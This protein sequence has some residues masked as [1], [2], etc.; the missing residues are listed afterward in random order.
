MGKAKNKIS[1]WSVYSKAL[2]NRGSI[3]FWIDDKAIDGCHCETHHGGR[4][5]G[6][7]FYDTAIE[8]GKWFS[9]TRLS[10]TAMYR[11]KTLVS[12]RLNLRSHDAQVAEMLA[13][14]SLETLQ[15]DIKFDEFSDLKMYNEWLPQ[16][17]EGVYQTLN[18]QSYFDRR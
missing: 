9:S 6:F 5:R 16:N 14:K 10:E 11:Y 3:T 8:T 18:E 17:I 2:V 4:G 15:Q 1:H 12:N 13:G 7:H